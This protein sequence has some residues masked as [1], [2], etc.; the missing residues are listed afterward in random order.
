MR[1]TEFAEDSFGTNPRRP[2]RT[3]ARH[4]RGHEPVP[5]YRTVKEFAPSAGGDPGDYLRALASA[6][7][8]DTFTSGSLQKGIKSQQDVERLLQRGIL[9]PDGKTRKY[10]I[11]YNGDFDGVEIYS[12]DYYEHGD[13][14]DTIDSRT[15]QK[16]G[17]YEFIEF[18]D[19]QLDE[20]LTEFAPPGGD[21]SGP[22][23]EE[24]LHRLASIWWTGTEQ[25]MIRAQRTL[26]SMGWKIGEDEGYDNGGVFVVRAGDEHGK[27]YIS[28]PHEDLSGSQ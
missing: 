25:Q 21:D 20:G 27:S 8:N 2:A 26:A 3:G 17:P 12:D 18:K 9:C 23:E 28:W 15:G 1:F 10:N 5:R 13:Y 14:D 19:D 11:D 16:W 6:W 4:P 7:Y 24:I 22:D